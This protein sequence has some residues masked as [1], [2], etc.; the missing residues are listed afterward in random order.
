MCSLLLSRPRG[1]GAF[2]KCKEKRESSFFFFFFFFLKNSQ[3]RGRTRKMRTT[4]TRRSSALSPSASSQRDSAAPPPHYHS[5]RRRHSSRRQT[6]RL[7]T[8]LIARASSSV[9]REL[10]E[11]RGNNPKGKNGFKLASD[12]ISAD[13][14]AWAARAGIVAPKLRIADFD[15]K[16]RSCYCARVGLVQKGVEWCRK[17]EIERK[18]G[19]R[20]KK[21]KLNLNTSLQPCLSRKKKASA[22]SSPRPPSPAARSSCASPS[23]RRSWCAPR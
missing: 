17:E 12:R 16:R 22:A 8:D 4:T 18:G 14:E 15:G 19:E 20:E 3:E 10:A 2:H 11:T 23:K 21:R 13:F 7:P 1:G 9:A 5:S 6:R